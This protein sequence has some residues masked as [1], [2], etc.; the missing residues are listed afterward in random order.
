MQQS[1]SH[2]KPSQSTRANHCLAWQQTG[3]SGEDTA[4]ADVTALRFECGVREFRK[5]DKD[6]RRGV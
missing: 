5:L 2:S 3:V 4:D 6:L 1:V